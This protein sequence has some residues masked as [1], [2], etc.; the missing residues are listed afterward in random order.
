VR[1]IEAATLI[2]FGTDDGLVAPE[3]GRVYKEHIPESFLIYVYGAAHAIQWGR[4]E[5]FVEVVADFLTRGEAFL[6]P[7]SA[8]AA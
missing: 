7:R 6:V 3:M 4:P 1:E 2:L 5:R 8:G